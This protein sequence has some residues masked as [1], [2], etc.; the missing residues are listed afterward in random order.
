MRV[1]VSHEVGGLHPRLLLDQQGV[2][3]ADE[4]VT[5]EAVRS[6]GEEG[7]GSEK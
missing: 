2:H 4:N 5:R 3:A 7:F 1:H 6:A